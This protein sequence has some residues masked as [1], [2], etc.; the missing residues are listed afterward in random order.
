MK[1]FKEFLLFPIFILLLVVIFSGMFILLNPNGSYVG[2]LEYLKLL[3]EDEYLASMLYNTFYI[4]FLISLGGTF[5]SVIVISF[6]K[7][8]MNY[9]IERKHYYYTIAAIGTG[10]TYATLLIF[11]DIFTDA[12]DI[13]TSSQNTIYTLIFSSIVAI[14]VTFVYWIIEL[15]VYIIKNTLKKEK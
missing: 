3:F 6:L 8:K 7:F 9:K 4:P 13:S 1:K 12:T 11:T 5:I 2:N 15:I 14:S 10:L